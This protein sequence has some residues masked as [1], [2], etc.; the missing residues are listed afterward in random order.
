MLSFC[1]FRLQ[2]QISVLS[3][4]L[5]EQCAQITREETVDL[6]FMSVIETIFKSLPCI[7]GSFL[8]ENDEHQCCN[9]RNP[10]VNI[11]EAEKAFELIRKMENESLKHVVSMRECD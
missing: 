2:T 11:E 9:I 7:N 10:G 5:A 4:N 1:L 3:V 6:D 8:T